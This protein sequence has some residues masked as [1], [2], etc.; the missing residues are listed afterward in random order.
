MSRYYI[1]YVWK[2]IGYTL[3]K[4]IN[5]IKEIVL[6][7]ILNVEI[8]DFIKN[9]EGRIS[10]AGRL[11]PMASGILPIV[12]AGKKYISKICDIFKNCN[13]TYRF[14]FYKDIRTD[15]YD[16]LGIINKTTED[17]LSIEHIKTKT[18]QKYPIYSSKTIKDPKT[19]KMRQLFE[20]GKEGR[21]DEIKHLI[22]E[23][24]IKINYIN[25][26]STIKK[27]GSEVLEDIFQEI[28]LLKSAD[29]R[30]EQIKQN[31]INNIIPDKLYD[32][33]K[34][35]ASVSSG[36]Y[37]RGLVNDMGG[38]AFNICRIKINNV[39]FLGSLEK[40]EDKLDINNILVLLIEKQ[41]YNL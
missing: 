11:D 18:S 28:D 35:E 36:T 34:Y 30:K 9:N 3:I 5:Y 7:N 41:I 21:I 29:F 26:I 20:F 19:D 25:E 15:S 33:C 31:W 39:Y 13:K 38:T 40:S 27:L 10:F 6:T 1:V 4:C 37:I 24:D 23:H 32:V 2:P 17:I 14:S 8:L 22:P 16:I 12:I